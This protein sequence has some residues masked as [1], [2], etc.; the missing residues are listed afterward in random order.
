MNVIAT[1]ER[2]CQ[3]WVFREV[4]QQ[5]QFNLRIVGREQHVTGLRYKR[6]ADLAPKL[7]TDRNV[8][9]VWVGGGEPSRRGAGLI[10]RGVDALCTRVD[11]YWQRVHVSALEL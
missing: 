7:R 6:C 2:F 9:Q 10:E 5:P 1:A 11:Q 4:G 3:Q 8:L